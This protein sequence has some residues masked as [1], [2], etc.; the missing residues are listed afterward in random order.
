MLCTTGNRSQAFNNICSIKKQFIF[1]TIIELYET[2]GL[3]TFYLSI[4]YTS[5][6]R[7]K[8]VLGVVAFSLDNLN[9]FIFI[10]TLIS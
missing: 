7:I 4:T 10:V 9:I 6:L 3:I 8:K 5:F 1:T 2:P